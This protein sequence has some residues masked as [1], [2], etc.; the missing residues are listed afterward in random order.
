MSDNDGKKVSSASSA[1]AFRKRTATSGIAARRGGLL[2]AAPVL[3]NE[4]K[5]D[6]EEEEEV[7][8]RQLA[9]VK[10]EQQLRKRQPGV[11]AEAI[12]K[13]A[14]SSSN[15]AVAKKNDGLVQLAFSSRDTLAASDST[16]LHPHEKLMREYVD[17]KLGH[18]KVAADP[19]LA[20]T[21]EDQLYRVPES[22]KVGGDN[23]TAAAAAGS[24]SS[25]SRATT[26]ENE[27]FSGLAE[28]VLPKSFQ[29]DNLKATK[30]ALES[31]ALGGGQS[32]DKRPL[33]K[34]FK[35][36]QDYKKRNLN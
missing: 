28:V 11:D 22:L 7:N 4:S 36:L 33:G 14:S 29:L 30:A 8:K 9:D 15:S 10:L 3:A 1:T 34:D 32:R 24:S 18:K 12:V 21:D 27:Y 35:V 17:E 5:E 31:S 20:A 26:G 13:K 2:V 6:D 16:A 23:E 19:Q 25:S